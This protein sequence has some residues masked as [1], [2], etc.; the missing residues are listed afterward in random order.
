[1]QQHSQKL[2]TNERYRQTALRYPGNTQQ[3]VNRTSQSLFFPFARMSLVFMQ[4]F[5]VSLNNTI[6]LNHLSPFKTWLWFSLRVL[7]ALAFPYTTC[8]QFI[9]YLPL[10]R[11]SSFFL[12]FQTKS[13][14]A[15]AQN[16]RKR[17]IEQ[18]KE[19]MRKKGMEIEKRRKVQFAPSKF[20]K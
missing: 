13:N 3:T 19:K 5:S 20:Y 9:T 15:H 14:E 11:P 4:H 8:S 10:V 17:R 16:K 18:L 2:L 12:F 1:M 7:I 6:D